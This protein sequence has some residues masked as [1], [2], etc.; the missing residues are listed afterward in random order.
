MT[1]MQVNIEVTYTAVQNRA[2][3]FHLGVGKYTP[4]MGVVGDMSWTP[5][6]IRQWKVVVNYWATLS[7][8]NSSRLNK[9]IALLGESSL[10]LYL[11]LSIVT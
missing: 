11:L 9:R 5:A 8:T 3:R 4:N 2:M 1:N 10:N 6:H 7:T